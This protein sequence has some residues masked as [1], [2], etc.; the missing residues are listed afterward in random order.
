MGYSS[1]ALVVCNYNEG[2]RLTVVRVKSILSV[3]AM[4]PFGDQSR[5]TQRYFLVEKF[6]LG[7]IDA[8]DAVE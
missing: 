5:Q 7:V 4:V 1:G 6:A 3:V 8:G 2:T